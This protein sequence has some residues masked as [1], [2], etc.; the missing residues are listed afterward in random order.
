MSIDDWEADVHAAS[1]AEDRMRA[2]EDE[3]RQ[4]VADARDEA[5]LDRGE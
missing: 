1:G 2:I 3:L 4:A 5:E